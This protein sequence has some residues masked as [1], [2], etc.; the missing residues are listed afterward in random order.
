[1]FVFLKY[2]VA[3]NINVNVE[4][5]YSLSLISRLLAHIKSKKTERV[6]QLTELP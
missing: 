5:Q 2:Y 4:P 1:M 3:L 6:F